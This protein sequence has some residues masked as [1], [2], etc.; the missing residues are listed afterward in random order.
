MNIVTK[1]KGKR[2]NKDF[3]LENSGES[4]GM[5]VFLVGDS[6]R[7]GGSGDTEEEL[8]MDKVSSLKKELKVARMFIIHLFHTCTLVKTPWYCM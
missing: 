8:D 5:G 2:T 6:A 7:R 1:M 3:T 4:E